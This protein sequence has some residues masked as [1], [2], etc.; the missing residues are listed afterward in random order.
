VSIQTIVISISLTLGLLVSTSLE[1]ARRRRIQPY[2]DRAC[3]GSKWKRSFPNTPNGQ[4]RQFL[5]LFAKR[6]H[7]SPKKQL[8]FSPEDKVMEIY[9][10]LYP[11]GS[12]IDSMELEF[13]V[14]DIQK[15]YGVDVI[16]FWRDDIT[17]GELFAYTQSKAA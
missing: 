13:F 3:N 2:L 15:I 12:A 10:A 5:G 14:R 6:F 11:P 17:L 4:I 7:F 1:L 16:R 8:S 9:W